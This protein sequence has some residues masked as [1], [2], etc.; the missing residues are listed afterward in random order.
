MGFGR[1]SNP[2]R[3]RCI[4]LPNYEI[5]INGKTRKI[6]ITKTG[7]ASF[8]AKIDDKLHNVELNANKLEFEKG[9]E[10]EVDSK[11]YKIELPLIPGWYSNASTSASM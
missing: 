10:I 11:T 4:T 7:Q 5:L 1:P 3:E 8:T 9:F 2:S 6:E